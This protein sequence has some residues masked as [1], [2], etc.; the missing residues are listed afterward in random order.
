MDF[1]GIK[2][3]YTKKMIEEELFY[4][5][6]HN[7]SEVGV[8]A[9]SMYVVRGSRYHLILPR[10]VPKSVIEHLEREDGYEPLSE[11]EIAHFESA[12]AQQSEQIQGQRVTAEGVYTFQG[13]ALHIPYIAVQETPE[14]SQYFALVALVPNEFGLI[15]YQR[16]IMATELPYI[17][18]KMHQTGQLIQDMTFLVA[19]NLFVHVELEPNLLTVSILEFETK[20]SE[21]GTIRVNETYAI[22]QM[23][24]HYLT[25]KGSEHAYF[26]PKGEHWVHEMLE[27][28]LTHIGLVASEIQA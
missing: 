27:R 3:V 7:D 8:V 26:E 4:R 14:Q 1:Y 21:R 6:S 17:L 22:K 5:V 2:T 15:K 20:E 19:N 18:M 11:V 9:L 16:P 28:F 10:E 12:M 24:E 23:G 25:L 13:D